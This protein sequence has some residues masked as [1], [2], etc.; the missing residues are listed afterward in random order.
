MNFEEF[1]F[2]REFVKASKK[3]IG[4]ENE[5]YWGE[6][7]GRKENGNWDVGTG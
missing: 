6:I 5:N 7:G 3:R 4:E 2:V 1:F